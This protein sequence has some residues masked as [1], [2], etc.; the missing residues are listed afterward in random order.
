MVTTIFPHHLIVFMIDDV[1]VPDVYV[2]LPHSD[3]RGYGEPSWEA[4][5]ARI[6]RHFAGVHLDCVLPSLFG[7]GRVASPCPE[8]R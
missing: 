5:R 8:V 2:T 4:N 7:R 6:H 1:A 3:Q